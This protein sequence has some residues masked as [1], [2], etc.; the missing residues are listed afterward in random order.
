MKVALVHDWLVT[1]RGGERV[2]EALCE[3]FPG[4]DIYTLLHQP[5]TMPPLIEDRRI[6]TS[7][8]QD[9]PGIHTRYRHFLPLFPRAIESFRLEGYE[10]VLS[11]SHCVAK[12]I[13]TPPGARHLG[14]IHA[15]MRY[16]WDLFDDYF[17]PGRAS[18][19]VRAAARSVR[20]WLQR[21]DRRTAAGVDRFVANSQH[22]AGKIHRFWGRDAHVVH[23]P[24]DLERFCAAPLEGTGQG[25]YFLWLG[26]FAP[27]KRLDIALEAFRALD[28]ELW[29]VGT[30]QE[31]SRLTSGAL[32]PHIRFLGNVPDARLPAL[33][34]DARALLFT[35]EE[36]FGITPLEAQATGRPV[37]AYAKGGVL[38]TVTPRTGLFFSEQT[39]EA[40]ATAVR[41]FEAWERTFSPAEARAQAQRF[42]RQAFLRGM[43]AEVEAL[44]NSPV[45]R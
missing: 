11:S 42:S 32:P 27:Y 12:G 43:Q 5:G 39:P 18:M 7:F 45:V 9:I 2:L 28:A 15:P 41:Q 34:R 13:R 4:A 21:W 31:A 36:D 23:P 40:L 20:P 33:Y 44:L 10:L 8:L 19:P 1:L 26:A 38:E 24:V 37:I 17:G 3:L 14:Y 29:V 35:G 6:Y 25:G 22:I 30:G 16:M